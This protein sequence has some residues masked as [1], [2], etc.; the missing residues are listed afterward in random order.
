LTL[1]HSNVALPV[2]I[3]EWD[4]F[5]HFQY[6]VVELLKSDTLTVHH[7][8]KLPDNGADGNDDLLIDG[9]LF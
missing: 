7:F 5:F 6:K 1:E 8:G 3:Q 9:I 4:L 2:G